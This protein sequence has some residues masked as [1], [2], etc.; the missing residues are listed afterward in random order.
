M[1]SWPVWII[2]NRASGVS[3][4]LITAELQN[5]L[6]SLPKMQTISWCA[7]TRAPP[8][9]LWNVV[10]HNAECNKA[11]IWCDFYLVL[12]NL[13][14]H[15][16][17]FLFTFT[18]S[19]KRTEEKMKME[20][21][22]PSQ[23]LSWLKGKQTTTLLCTC[24]S[25]CPNTRCFC[26][27][28][29]CVRRLGS[30]HVY[31]GIQ[32]LAEISA[33]IC[34]DIL[35]ILFTPDLTNRRAA[36]PV[37]SAEI[38]RIFF[39]AAALTAKSNFSYRS[40]RRVTFKQTTKH[41]HHVSG[42][43]SVRVQSNNQPPRFWQHWLCPAV[44]GRFTHILTLLGLLDPLLGARKQPYCSMHFKLLYNTWDKS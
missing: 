35:T 20:S 31:A 10:I 13:T 22:L 1:L 26:C 38:W 14:T 40:N 18:K 25:W 42:L 32:Q 6:V 34:L 7:L 15:H 29:F 3:E 27:C 44:T 39:S 33:W 30:N 41:D 23:K 36:S 8:D 16:N 37:V 9:V 4:V 24:L 21:A 11:C 43:Q 12:V 28:W 5:G 19:Q 17:C 2:R